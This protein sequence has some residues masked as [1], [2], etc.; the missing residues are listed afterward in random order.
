MN[1]QAIEFN[2]QNIA[3]MTIWLLFY[4]IS[5]EYNFHFFHLM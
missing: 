2:K 3:V 5:Y 1:I 4:Y